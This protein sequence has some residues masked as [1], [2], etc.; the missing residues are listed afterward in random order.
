MNASNHEFPIKNLPISQIRRDGGTQ[1]R[2][3]I[4]REVIAEY[5]SDMARGDQFPPV[6]VFQDGKNVWLVDGFHRVAAA[7]KNGDR[8]ISAEVHKGDKR[9]A[10][11]FSVGVN[12]DHGWRRTTDDKR[13]S[14]KHLLAYPDWAKWSDREIGRRCDVDHKT[15]ASI[16]K[17]HWGISPVT[18]E[19][20]Y[21]TKHG[22]Q[23]TMNTANIGKSEPSSDPEPDETTTNVVASG[24][25]SESKP[26]PAPIEAASSVEPVSKL[27]ATLA[28]MTDEDRARLKHNLGSD[29]DNKPI[30]ALMLI[31][32]N[33][34]KLPSPE[35]SVRRTPP[36][37]FEDT[38]FPPIEAAAVWLSEFVNQWKAR[39]DTY[40]TTL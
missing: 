25:V 3:K 24:S 9:D 39:K 6:T 34:A 12:A 8:Q 13:I 36:A 7:L 4:S 35:E 11:L 10:I 33:I 5:A 1:P 17:S 2:A 27:E 32:L 22:T 21:T 23:A 38:N 28:N 20:T 16:R 30:K 15:V 40:D 37:A 26:V 18:N 14:V 31:A 19:R 29:E